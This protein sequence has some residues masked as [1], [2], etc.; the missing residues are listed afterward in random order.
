LGQRI[1][2]RLI[3]RRESVEKKRGEKR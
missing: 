1:V 2:R 3:G